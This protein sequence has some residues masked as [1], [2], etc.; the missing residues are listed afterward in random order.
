[1]NWA[2][3]PF[4][5]RP[6]VL[7]S[8]LLTAPLAVAA[9]PGVKASPEEVVLGQDTQVVL[10]V[11]VPPGS[12]P[13]RAAASSGAF[14]SNAVEG[15]AVRTFRWTPPEVRHPLTAVLLFWVEGP[16]A[17]PP[18]VARVRLALL[19]RTTLEISTS[20]GAEVVVEVANRRFGPVLANAAGQAQVPVEVPPGV[21]HARVLATRGNQKT[22]RTTP[23]HAPP[24][25]PLAVALGPTPMPPA[26]G[27][28]VVAGTEDTAPT[29]VT[30]SARGAKALPLEG[31]P[32]HFRVLPAAGADT[33]SVEARRKKGT[34]RARAEA[35]VRAA[36]AP[37]RPPR[38][39]EPP[40]PPAAEAPRREGLALHLLAGGFLARGANTGL[41][42]AIGA[43]YP[44]P[45][46]DGRLA[47]ELEVGLRHASLEAV[48]AFGVTRHSRVLAGPI[49]ASARL[50]ALE[51]G[52]FSL[53][54]R[55]GGGVMPFEHQLTIDFQK[56][57][58]ESKLAPMVFLA[59][60]GAY[61]MRAVSVLLELRGAYGVARTPW[62]EAQ[63]GGVAATVGVRFSP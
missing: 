30:V 26:G 27:W 36:P 58:E 35:P 8:L 10:E 39:P 44:L 11:R 20:P 29:D 43:S 16:Q 31:K 23:L 17:K 37:V 46:W 48:D 7:L 56:E 62:L 45:V 12:G 1:M 54:G 32:G 61:R 40:Q 14:A 51:W 6:L 55:V 52:A 4:R 53:Y 49:L 25:R 60:Q 41:A 47:A 42:A 57:V 5:M 33:V 24:H 13:V 22:D 9:P 63:L 18:E 50:T 21:T 19:G 3:P 59:A 28:A 38:P 2:A 15:G 34:D